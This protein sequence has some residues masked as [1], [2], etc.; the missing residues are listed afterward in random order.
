[1]IP[2]LKSGRV[3]IWGAQR[4]QSN[5]ACAPACDPE[6]EKHFKSLK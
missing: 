5:G 3:G 6:S 2:R 1:L 4:P